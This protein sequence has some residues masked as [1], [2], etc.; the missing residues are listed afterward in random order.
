MCAFIKRGEGY[1][2]KSGGS[3]IVP[4]KSCAAKPLKRELSRASGVYPIEMTSVGDSELMARMQ[5]GDRAAF[6]MLVDRHKHKLVNYLTGMVRDRD[7]SEE[8]AQ[9]VFL[10]LYQHRG[11]YQERGQFLP[12]LYRIATNLARSEE[13]KRR[14]REFLLKTFAKP[15]G[16]ATTSSSRARR[17]SS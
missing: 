12:Y 16:T 8:L 5:R 15:T 10:K 3:G 14:R 6:A 4:Q 9:D 2:M 7:R 17:R 11:R 13:R 1:F